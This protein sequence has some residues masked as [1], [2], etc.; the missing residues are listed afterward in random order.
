MITPE[1][2]NEIPESFVKEIEE[3]ENYI[4]SDIARRIAKEGEITDTAAIELNRALELGTD[5]SVIERFIERVTGAIQEDIDIVLRGVIK[6]SVDADNVIYK[7]AGYNPVD[8]KKSS[9]LMEIIEAG[10]R[11]TNSTL[12][13][14]TGSMGFANA[15]GGK[16]VFQ[17]I[18]KFYQNTLDFALLQVSTGVLD[19]NSAARFAVKKMADSG[20][21]YV[22]YASGHV[23]RVDV[24]VKRA[25]LTGVNQ[26]N[27]R[28]TDGIMEELGA[29]YVVLF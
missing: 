25:I 27:L 13:N 18:A 2:L 7:A 23:N 24:A 12:K 5:I 3:L 26:L 29:E 22:D 19:V 10:I 9:K 16:T 28:I 11:Q 17:D 14:I 4:I 15:V 6:E 21:R 1:Q 20:I 8:L